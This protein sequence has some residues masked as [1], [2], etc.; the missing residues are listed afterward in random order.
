[1]A[2]GALLIREAGGT[3]TNFDGEKDF[4]FGGNV[5]ATNGILHPVFL[6]TLK[7]FIG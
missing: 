6:R 2:A 7:D 4:L 3:I 5:V 1:M